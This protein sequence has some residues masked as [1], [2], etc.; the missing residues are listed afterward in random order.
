MTKR[1]K[2]YELVRKYGLQNEIEEKYH[3]NFTQV[4]THLIEDLIRKKEEILFGD[5]N[6]PKYDEHSFH[7]NSHDAE[8][9]AAKAVKNIEAYEN[10]AADIKAAE[11]AKATQVTQTKLWPNYKMSHEQYMQYQHKCIED[12]EK[13]HNLSADG[14]SW[15]ERS[16]RAL[17]TKPELEYKNHEPAHS[18]HW[19]EDMLSKMKEKGLI[20]NIDELKAFFKKSEPERK[21]DIQEILDRL[22]TIICL[23]R[24]IH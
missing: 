9:V 10:K 8:T 13:K 23:L 18:T 22:D 16:I 4:S 17:N 24:N 1:Q 14:L 3:R 5:R 20:R 19:Y 15:D 11:A 7:F 21:Y 12:I 6:L 2:I